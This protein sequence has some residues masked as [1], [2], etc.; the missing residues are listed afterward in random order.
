MQQEKVIITCALTGA[1]PASTQHPNFTKTPA[2]IAQQGIEAAEAGAAILHIHVRDEDGKPS[3]EFEHYKYVCDEIRKKNTDVIFNLTTGPGCMW[4]QSDD[5]PSMPGPGSSM[6]T[7][8]RRLEHVMKL[9][10]EVCTLDICTMQIFG[11]IAI[12][13]DKMITRMGGMIKDAGV[14]PEIECFDTGDYV[15]AQDLI[16]KGALDGPGMYSFVLGTKYGLVATPEAMI[17]SRA[18]MPAG[19]VWTGFGVSRHSFSMAAQS[20]LLGGHVRTGF[21]DTLWLSRGN[22]APSN[23]ALVTRAS[24]IIERL[25]SKVA[26]PGEARKLLGLKEH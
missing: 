16:A 25:G 21:E 5:D 7:A 20:V 10:P 3:T 14:K 1:S 2:Q 11:G 9:Q 24:E 6:L 17:Y 4:Q 22:L 26:T 23:A 19:A 13:T 8:E 15:F 12:N 18:Q